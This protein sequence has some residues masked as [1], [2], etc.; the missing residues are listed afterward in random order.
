MIIVV[1]R[2]SAFDTILL[3]PTLAGHIRHIRMFRWSPL[4]HDH[5]PSA[6]ELTPTFRHN[7][8]DSVPRTGPE[9]PYRTWPAREYGP[10][11]VRVHSVRG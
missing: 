2:S 6:P 4:D 11:L 7:L 1:Q 5:T 3:H 8:A 9:L 10:G